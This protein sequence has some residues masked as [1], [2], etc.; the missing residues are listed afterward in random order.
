MIPEK[1]R[2]SGGA[3]ANPVANSTAPSSNAL[4]LI[5]AL[6][7][8]STSVVLPNHRVQK[9]TW[10]APWK[11]MRVI[12]GHQGWVRCIAVDPMN[13][14]FVTGSNDRTIKFWDLIEGKLKITLTGHISTVRALATS[15]RYPYLFSCGEDKQVKCWDL[16]QNKTVRQFHGHLSGVYCMTLHPTLDVLVTG[17][18]DSTA[19]V[20]D[21]RTKAQIHVLGGHK[22]TV[23]TVAA[24]DF[25]P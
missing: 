14:W 10:H 24:Q 22:H 6:Q 5:T 7:H 4:S 1:Y 21:I 13:R 23:S 9:P 12:A 25:E 2:A 20:W 3:G 8:N 16:E 11:L 17:G 15:A 19:R 18:R